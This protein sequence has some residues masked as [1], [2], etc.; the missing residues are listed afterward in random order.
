MRFVRQFKP[1]IA[2]TLRFRHDQIANFQSAAGYAPAIPMF[3]IRAGF[4]VCAASPN[5]A[6][7]S[8]IPTPD[9]TQARPPA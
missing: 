4:K 3:I 6:N 5:F 1:N 7:V 8:G 9:T 2:V